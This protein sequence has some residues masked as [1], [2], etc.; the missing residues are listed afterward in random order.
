MFISQNPY[1]PEGR[2]KMLM[3]VKVLKAKLFSLSNSITAFYLTTGLHS[4]ASSPP[5]CDSDYALTGS[6]MHVTSVCLIFVLKAVSFW[7][8]N[9]AQGK[10]S[11]KPKDCQ[12]CQW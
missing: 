6:K 11:L 1:Y 4:Q 2:S 12:V 3:F 7:S 5:S 10:C 9:S 8:L